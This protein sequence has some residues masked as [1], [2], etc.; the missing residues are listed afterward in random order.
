MLALLDYKG[1]QVRKAR[2][3]FNEATNDKVSL[4]DIVYFPLSMWLMVGICVSFYIA[5]F[6]FVQFGRYLFSCLNYL[7]VY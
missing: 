2:G 7:T 4:R 6:I 1:E 5:V 3:T